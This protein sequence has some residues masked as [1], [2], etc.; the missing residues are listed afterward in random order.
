M[1][2]CQPSRIGRPA[3]PFF[4]S[5][6]QGQQRATGRVAVP[7]PALVRRRDLESWDMWQRRSPPWLGGEAQSYKTCGSTI[8]H[9]SR[10]ARSG[11][12]GHMVASE[13]TSIGRRGSEV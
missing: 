5:E 4:I 10:E 3:K 12:A 13:P 9:L 2:I 1:E 8:A 6:A 7:E 11:A